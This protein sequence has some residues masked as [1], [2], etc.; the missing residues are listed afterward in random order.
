VILGSAAAVGAGYAVAVDAA[1]H[2]AHLS[3]RGVSLAVA[4]PVTL[5]VVSV[6]ALHVQ[7]WTDRGTKSAIALVVAAA[8]LV[9][10]VAAVPV[11]V[12]GVLLALGIVAFEVNARRTMPTSTTADE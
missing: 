6:W 11:V 9:A 12:I 10:G 5:Y 1:L 7:G 2:H 3:A 8:I 4:V